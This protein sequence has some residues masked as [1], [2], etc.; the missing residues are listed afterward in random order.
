MGKTSTAVKQRYKDKVYSR[1]FASVPKQLAADFRKK[2]AETGI[3]Q[4]QVIKDAIIRF[5]AENKKE[6][7]K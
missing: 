2:C 7:L 1:I 5:L 4:A 6:D 3:P